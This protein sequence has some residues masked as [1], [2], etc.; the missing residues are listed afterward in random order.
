MQSE[1]IPH[2]FD[3]AP[4]YWDY[5]GLFDYPIGDGNLSVRVFGSDDQLAVVNPDVNDTEPDPNDGFETQIAFHRADLVWEAEHG[6]WTV[7]LTP[8]FRHDLFSGAGG[9]LFSFRVIQ[10]LF[11]FRGELGYRMRWRAL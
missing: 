8:S 9:D 6:P 3:V 4:R 7:L 10:D 11:S 2:D 5:Q 1:S